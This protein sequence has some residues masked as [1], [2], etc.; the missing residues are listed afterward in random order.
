MV[1]WLTLARQPPTI[2]PLAVPARTVRRL[3]MDRPVP[4]DLIALAE[5][6]VG[7]IGW[8]EESGEG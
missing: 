3:A 6:R 5:G 7:G 2:P 4:D 1:V 8:D